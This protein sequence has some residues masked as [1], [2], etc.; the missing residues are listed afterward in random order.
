MA[1][2]AHTYQYNPAIR[3]GPRNEPASVT[4]LALIGSTTAKARYCL[5]IFSRPCSKVHKLITNPL[6]VGNFP[7]V[8]CENWWHRSGLAGRCEG[9]RA[10]FR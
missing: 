4:G 6:A 7:R 10:L 3:L 9:E 8:S 1:I 2:C 5:E